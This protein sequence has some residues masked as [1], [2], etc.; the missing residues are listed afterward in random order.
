[1]T[2]ALVE[3]VCPDRR[4]GH[5]TLQSDNPNGSLAIQELRSGE[6]KSAA[7]TEAAKEGVP[8]P[9]VNGMTLAPYPIT[10]DGQ[11]VTDPVNQKVAAYRV[12]V[13]I[14]AKLV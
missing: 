2:I 9:R 11:T 13:P 8:D 4:A 12:D 10:E 5:V 14:T 3:V 6:A 7:I 1:M